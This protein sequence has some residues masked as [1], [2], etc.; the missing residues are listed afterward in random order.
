MSDLDLDLSGIDAARALPER[1]R[2][3]LE[4]ALTARSWDEPDADLLAGIDAP[5]AVPGA[6]RARLEGVVHA[7]GR[8]LLDALDSPRAMPPGVRARLEHRL[9][10]PARPRVLAQRALALAAG[11]MLV[12]ASAAVFVRSGNG[13]GTAPGTGSAFAP[14]PGAGAFADPLL[15]PDPATAMAL[16]PGQGAGGI[17]GEFLDAPGL[18]AP[19]PLV[20][21]PAPPFAFEAEVPAPAP[22]SASAGSGGGTTGSSTAEPP[23]IEAEP[24]T[25]GVIGGNAAQERGFRRYIRLLNRQGGVQ[26]HRIRV[27]AAGEDASPRGS[28]ATV[29]LSGAAVAAAEGPPGWVRGPLLETSAA[30]EDVQHGAVYSFASPPERLARLIARARYPEPVQTATTALI[31]TTGGAPWSE[32]VPAAIEE[33]LRSQGVA[34]VRIAYQESGT[35]PV[36]LP[37]DVAFLSMDGTSAGRWLDDARDANYH[38]ARGIA[39]VYP[40]VD[41]ALAS[42]FSDRE[43]W[44]VAPYALLDT[45][46]TRALRGSSD[47][48]GMDHVHGWVTAKMLAVAIWLH[49]VHKPADMRAALDALEGYANGFAPPYQTR[50]SSN[51][52]TPEGILYELSGGVFVPRSGFLRDRA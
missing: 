23:T 7:T 20:R 14:A 49:D 48:V 26:G 12:V 39:G 11:I 5:R 9:V 4:H 46:E 24:L 35:P 21:G 42:W 41:T 2:A 47:D 27:A 18:I 19:G 36:F 31:Y 22:D 17:A 50:A 6:V 44:A 38:P 43:V 16:E 15:P 32:A 30:T 33:V 29:N 3:R 51:A 40:L 45:L 13:P 8:E 28:I 1:L 25:V 37:A 34:A 52:R 10:R